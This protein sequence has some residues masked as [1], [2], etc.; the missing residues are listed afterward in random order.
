MNSG[1]IGLRLV[2]GVLL[3][4]ANGFFVAIEFALTRAR[5][6]TEDEFVDGNSKLERAWEMTQDLELYLTTCQVGITASSIAVGIVAEPAL[7]ALFE[8]LFGGTALARIGAG[9]IIAYA[10]I[11]LI[12]LTHGE[13]APTYLGVERSRMVCRYGATPLYWFYLLI[14]P[15][16]TLGD[17]VA[18]WTLRLFGIEMTGAWLEAEEDAI[19]TRAQLRNRMSSLLEQGEISDERHDEIVNALAAGRTE[20]RDVM[21]DEEDMVPLSTT[22]SVEENLRRVSETPHT[23]YPLI[24]EDTDE[25]EGVVYV[26]SVVD[27]IEELKAGDVTFAEIAAPPMTVSADT[28]VSDAIDQ[29]Q[30]E[31]Q[32]LALVLSEGDVV[33]LLTATDALE[34]V[35]GELEDPLDREYE[36]DQSGLGQATPE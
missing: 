5:Q 34:A 33:G 25:F 18:K 19:E 23:R 36:S 6:F 26:P 4:L 7:A 29:F 24:G 16:I 31:R 30:A 27:C 3:I 20:V 17:Y 28:T 12:H 15:L 21:V 1:E 22:V 10:I 8:P 2:A 13:Q 35:M 14:S 32:E 11:N 9:A